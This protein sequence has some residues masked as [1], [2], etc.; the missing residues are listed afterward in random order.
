MFN[1]QD[2][3]NNQQQ[4]KTEEAKDI[5]AEIDGGGENIANRRF[6]GMRKNGEKKDL[7]DQ[8]RQLEQQGLE[9]K[10]DRQRQGRKRDVIKKIVISIV[11]VSVLVIVAITYYYFFYKTQNIM[12]L[13]R[14]LTDYFFYKQQNS[15][16]GSDADIV[17]I[18]NTNQ[19]VENNIDK[20][21][22]SDFDGLTDEEEKIFGTN[23]NFADSDEDG[24]LDKEEI[25]VYHTDPMNF[26]TDGD[27]YSDGDEVK[28]GYNPNGEGKLQ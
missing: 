7:T 14:R 4:N 28:S 12:M 9:D 10:I 25:E 2:N 3:L 24:L 23:P 22:D 27:G 5:F 17:N 11:I 15:K 8:E 16:D 13:K 19:P 20:P 21:I 26:D 18:I 6:P 1:K